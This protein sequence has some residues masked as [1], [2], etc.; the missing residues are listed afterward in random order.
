MWGIG[1]NN[2]RLEPEVRY[3]LSSTHNQLL[4]TAVELGIPAMISYLAILLLLGY[5]CI[6][7][8]KTSNDVWMRI[9]ALGLGWGQ[10]AF[11]FFGFTDAI[12]PGAKVGIL[13]WISFA[14]ITALYKLK[15][16]LADGMM[17]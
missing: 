3:F 8:W 10:L 15:Y 14:L 12:P 2:F 11:F 17:E 4:H 6:Q 13:F 1:L 7:V 9:A 5:M 16:N